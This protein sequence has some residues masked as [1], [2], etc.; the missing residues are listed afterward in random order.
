MQSPVLPERGE[1]WRDGSV[2]KNVRESKSPVPM[3]KP[4]MAMCACNF[5]IGDRQAD[6]R[7]SDTI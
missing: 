5:S 7:S 1:R 4:G 3:Q 6:L 2:D